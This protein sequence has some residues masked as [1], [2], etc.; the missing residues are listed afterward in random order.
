MIE[1][2]YNFATRWSENGAVYM[3]ADLHLGQSDDLRQAYPNRPTDEELV[4]R[5]N[6]QTGR[7]SYLVICGDIGDDLELIGKL[8]PH[9][10]LLRGN[11]DH[12]ADYYKD[13]VDEYYEGM[14]MIS[15]KIL[16]SHEPFSTPYTWNISGHNHSG[17]HMD[18]TKGITNVCIDVMNYKVL[19][20]NQFVKSGVLKTVK[21]IHQE[22][23]NAA[24]IRKAKRGGR[25]IGEK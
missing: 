9:I 10:I 20:F 25:K 16:L 19:N 11:H 12:L 7:N 4:K 14:L 24:T 22:T 13:V 8:R 1:G 17:A 2:L 6:T 23:V 18:Y 15:P 21:S 3:C 5:I